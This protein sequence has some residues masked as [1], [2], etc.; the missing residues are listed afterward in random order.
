MIITE[1]SLRL[2]AVIVLTSACAGRAA[3]SVDER[4]DT[5]VRGNSSVI[6]REEI[7]TLGSGDMSALDVVKRLRP[8]YLAPRAA[9]ST[10]NKEAGRTHAS[11]DGVGVVPIEDLNNVHAASIAEITFLDSGRAMQKFGTRA[12]RGAVI[13][14]RLE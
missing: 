5:P 2:F 10:T 12:N 3:S 9:L 14:V 11:I 1:K 13:V 8:M 4:P 6:T 7:L